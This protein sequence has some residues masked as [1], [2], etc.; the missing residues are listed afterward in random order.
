MHI[1][2]AFAFG[3]ITMEKQRD[4]ESLIVLVI[5]RGVD[6]LIVILVTKQTI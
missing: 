2:N 4:L 5:D 3:M 1:D 6:V